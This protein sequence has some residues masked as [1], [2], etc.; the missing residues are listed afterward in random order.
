MNGG[1]LPAHALRTALSDGLNQPNSAVIF[2]VTILVFAGNPTPVRVLIFVFCV[3]DSTIVL[4]VSL[5]LVSSMPF[6]D[7]LAD[8]AELGFKQE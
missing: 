1:L 5:I 2:G 4:P 3:I 6:Y 8:G 7:G